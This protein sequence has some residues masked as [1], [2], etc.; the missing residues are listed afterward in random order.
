MDV[1][2][3]SPLRSGLPASVGILVVLAGNLVAQSAVPVSQNTLFFKDPGGI[4]LGALVV[5]TP[6]VPGRASGRFVEV[7][8]EGW[9]WT[10]STGADQREGFDLS[11]GAAEGENLRAAPN[12][13]VLAR[14]VQGTLFKRVSVRRGWTQVRRGVWIARSAVPVL[15][16]Q[17]SDSGEM[18]RRPA[19]PPSTN[20]L[21][22]GPVVQPPLA[23][24]GRLATLR[25]GASLK[26]APDGQPVATLAA[27][28]EVA[29][30][31]QSGEWVKVRL[32]GWVRRSEVDSAV[33][34]RPAITAA[35]LR[36]APERYLGQRVDWRVQFL[37][38]HHAD[39]LRPEMPLGHPYL[40]ARGP[41]P[42]SGF[43][44]VMVSKEQSDRFQGLTPLEELALTVTVRAGRTRYLAT[45]VVELVRRN[46]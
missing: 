41:L 9:I 28:A 16:D 11:V 40:L 24:E 37:A 26:R 3:S 15:A 22:S 6:V 29:A 23:P 46:P 5:G 45:P 42:E 44:Y 10:A 18:A 30:G 17:R 13:A 1:P 20:P 21:P 31:E 2:Q 25:A 43:V 32:E 34:P 7:V 4:R 19:V 33:A 39:E 12:G 35:M 14:A 36:E 38:L 8:L 27:P